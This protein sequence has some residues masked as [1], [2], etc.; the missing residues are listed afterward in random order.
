MVNYGISGLRNKND[1]LSY[2]THK[3]CS[4]MFA[5]TSLLGNMVKNFTMQ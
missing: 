1:S 4:D 3:T 2:D 5:V